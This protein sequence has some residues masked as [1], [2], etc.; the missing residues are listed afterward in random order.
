MGKN[1]NAGK[2]DPVFDE[3][4]NRHL[5]GRTTANN[6]RN[7]RTLVHERMYI[8]ILTELATN[9][10]KWTGLPDS[11]DP[12]FLEMTL[13]RNALAVFYFDRDFGKFFALQGSGIGP[14]NMMNNPTHFLVHGTEFNSKTLRAFNSVIDVAGMPTSQPLECVPIWSNY[15]RM[16][17]LDI[18]MLYAT[19][20][21]ELDTTIEI[22]TKSARRGK[23]LTYDE[24]AKLTAENINRQIDE[25]QATIAVRP[26]IMDGML[27]SI[28]L[29]VNPESIVSLSMLRARHWNDCMTLLGIDN[30]NQDKKE[31]LVASE[32]DANN[33]QIDGARAV[34]LNARKQAAFAINEAFGLAI[35]VEYNAD[36]KRELDTI[37]FGA[38][39]IELEAV[40]DEPKGIEA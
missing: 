35:N 36:V 21:A 16:P 20:L 33:D 4:H 11:V 19:K 31:R 5:R 17:D 26:G 22:N 8:R 39:M 30:S 34:S 32:V 1:R 9:R 28:D 3:L 24:N 25:G 38:T 10:F 2:S 6:P 14:V 27:Q 40:E 15:L 13:F 29:G 23:V 7:N 12:R 37:S 18:V